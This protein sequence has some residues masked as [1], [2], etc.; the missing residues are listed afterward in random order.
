M[1]LSLAVFV[2]ALVAC[3]YGSS[4]SEAPGTAKMP[5]ADNTDFYA[6]RSYE[7]SRLNAS[8]VTFIVNIEGLQSPFGGPNYYSF[9]DQHFYEIYVDNTGDLV[10]DLV[11]QF[12]YGN[13]LGGDT[14]NGTIYP[15]DFDCTYQGVNNTPIAGGIALPIGPSNGMIAIPLKTAGSIAVNNNPNGISPNLN[16]I[17]FYYIHVINVRFFC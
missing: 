2:L 6:F 7:P 11:Y 17:E 5:Q 12:I 15:A 10:E 4:H 13:S 14:I 16:W 1:Q 9:S 8:Y 3:A